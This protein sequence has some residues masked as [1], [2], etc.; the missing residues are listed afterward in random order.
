MLA[1]SLQ[2]QRDIIRTPRKTAMRHLAPRLLIPTV[3]VAALFALGEP[4]PPPCDA[5]LAQLVEEAATA[6]RQSLIVLE[7][8]LRQAK[9]SRM[10]LVL[11][12]PAVGR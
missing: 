5:P 7:G 6:G 12:L 1:R 3:A 8:D 11:T 4:L 9:A 2:Q 10:R